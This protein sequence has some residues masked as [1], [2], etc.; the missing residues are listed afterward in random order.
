EQK[1][2][3]LLTSTVQPRTWS[4]V[5]GPATIDYFPLTMSLVV[6]QTPGVHE[7]IQELLTALRRLQD[8]EVTVELR[9]FTVSQPM[10]QQLMA[11]AP[12]QTTPGVAVLDDTQLRVLL[13]TVQAD[14]GA[15]IMQAPKVTMFNGQRASVDLTEKQAFVVGVDFEE[16]GATKLPVTRT[17]VVTT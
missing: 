6:N 4:E 7:Q 8:V 15:R 5:G 14:R 3:K 2:I 16:K 10:S 13:E 12:Q 11:S 17:K 1:L 9:F